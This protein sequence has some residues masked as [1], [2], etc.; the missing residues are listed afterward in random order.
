M[1]VCKMLDTLGDTSKTDK[2]P[3]GERLATAYMQRT[4]RNVKGIE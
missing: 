1:L 2:P 3:K 4:S